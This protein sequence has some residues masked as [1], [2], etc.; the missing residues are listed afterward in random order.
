MKYEVISANYL[1]DYKIELK[2]RDGTTG[3]VDLQVFLGKGRLIQPLLNIDFFRCFKVN[4]DLGTLVW[5]N[6]YDIAPDTLY[7]LVT[8]KHDHISG[9][10][11]YIMRAN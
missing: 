9:L 11:E 5:E 1:H 6:G 10:P 4:A 7:Y 2:F 8:G 3:I